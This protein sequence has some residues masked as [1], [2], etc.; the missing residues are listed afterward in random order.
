MNPK[1]TLIGTVLAVSALSLPFIITEFSTKS[2]ISNTPD[3][4]LIDELI[5]LECNELTINYLIDSSNLLDKEFNGSYLIDA[6]ELPY[7]LLQEDL[8]K[9]VRIIISV[10]G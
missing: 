7:G 2:Q 6:I 5:K 8:D 9:C 1:I 10:R 4:E 3:L